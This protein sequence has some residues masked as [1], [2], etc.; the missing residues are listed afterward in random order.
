M[1]RSHSDHQEVRTLKLTPL[2]K[3]VKRG[4]A[5]SS[6]V[7]VSSAMISTPA[8]AQSESGDLVLEEIIV[9]A[10]KR[11]QS[12]QDV[13]IA[14]TA[15]NSRKIEELGIQSF[16]DYALMMPNVSFKS[17]G[18]PGGA[19]I[20]MRGA[21]DGGDANP[22]GSAPSVG[23]YLDEQP[24]T[25]I[26]S[27]LDV[28]IYDIER[29]EALGGPQGTLFGASSQSGTIR[30]ITNKPDTSAFEAGFDIGA[31]GTDSGDASYS[32][33]GFLNQPLGERAAL[34]VVAWYL[35]EGGWIDNIAGSRTYA[36]EGGYGYNGDP[37][38]PYGRTRTINNDHLVKKNFNDLTKTGGRAALKVDLSDSWVGTL[39]V[40][41]QKIESEGVWEH[42]PDNVGKY[43]IQRFNPDFQE[44]KFTQLGVTIEGNL[45]NHQ[46]VY[47]GAFL[48]RT[49]DY[50]T[51]YSAYGEDAYF[52]PYYACDYSATGIDL[53][54]QS[55][56]DCTSLEEFYTE[57]N[58]Y[59]R[60]SHEIRLVST[61]DGRLNYTVGVYYEKFEHDY[62][63][64]WIQ[65]EM[66]PNRYVDGEPGLY[67]RTDQVRT[68]KQT[69]LFGEI[70]YAFTDSLTGSFGMRYFDEDHSVTG[71]VGWGQ[72]LF[73]VNDTLADSKVSNDDTIFKGNLTWR[74]N[75]NRMVYF[76]Y[77]EGYRPGGLN[78]DPGLPSQAWIPDKVKN[79]EIGW[80]TTSDDG[81]LRF[82]GAAYLMDWS[83]IQYTVYN[84]FLSACCGNVYNLSTAQILGLEADITYAASEA[85]TLSAAF[86]YND[87]ETTD[88]FVLPNGLLS[89][90]DGTALP[91]VPEWKGNILARYE[92]NMSDMPAYAQL[93]WSY[94]GKSWSE[95]VPNTV[96]KPENRFPQKSYSI[97]NFRTGINKGSWGVDLYVNNLTNEAAE[98]YV[99]PRNYEPTT[100]VNRPRNYGLK[101]WKRY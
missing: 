69:S 79:Y 77:S 75:D 62:F 3:A 9:T 41:T 92:F 66:S 61:G 31:G 7:V 87:G 59:D 1:K 34:R 23:L 95:I 5:Y 73:G 43:K 99:H 71:V 49:V 94:T 29:I 55:N 85:W 40:I 6:M 11:E 12:L 15:F 17:F 96:T 97:A 83:D 28:H 35:E 16:S 98:I 44:D 20:Y 80:K 22:S 57:D 63:L 101:F 60:T 54:T 38:A 76:T 39:S 24:V 82:N 88:D 4:L 81:R 100:V 18:A 78:R 2:S 68:D 46:L 91:N 42:D 86:A 10:Q 25:S 36:L 27:N 21:S 32:A 67:F 8:M 93:A 74:I 84:F 89:V 37:N 45:E 72:A 90:P 14:V 30:I 47:A 48:D 70:S 26:G 58:E 56:T 19:T 50:Q 65:P 53:A 51:D 33:E 52:V 64:K 13:P